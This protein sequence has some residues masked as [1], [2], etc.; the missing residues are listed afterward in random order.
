MELK[1]EQQLYLRC[2]DGDT[3][4]FR[5]IVE[6]YQA[7]VFSVAFRLLCQEDAAKDVVQETFIR[8]WVNFN[9]YD[10]TKSFRTWLYTIATRVCLDYLKGRSHLVECGP[11]DL[12]YNVI[13]DLASDQKIQNDE[14]AAIIKVLTQKLSYKQRLVFTLVCLE[15]LTYEEVQQITGLSP[16]KIK[17]NIYLARKRMKELLKQFGYE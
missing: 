16:D 14:L 17:S 13:S 10:L 6:R 7:L 12:S 15:D 3:E 4:A 5:L 1:D 11:V 9:K 8:V 2:L